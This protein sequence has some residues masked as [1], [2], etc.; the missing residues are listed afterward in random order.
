[1]C[2]AKPELKNYF[3]L[4]CYPK[5]CH[6]HKPNVLLLHLRIKMCVCVV[7]VCVFKKQSGTQ[8]S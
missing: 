6:Y 2:I 3:F 7:F 8:T 4:I 5:T 1:M